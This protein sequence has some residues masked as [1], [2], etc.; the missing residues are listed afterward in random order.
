M[1]ASLQRAPKAMDV[2]CAPWSVVINDSRKPLQVLR[3]GGL[4]MRHLWQIRSQFES[5]KGVTAAIESILSELQSQLERLCWINPSWILF[6]I[7][8]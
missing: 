1:P 5:V 6:G 7:K 4:I 8:T 3:R 2:Y